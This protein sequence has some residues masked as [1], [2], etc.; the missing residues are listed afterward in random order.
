MRLETRITRWI[1][2]AGG[3]LSVAGLATFAQA[4]PVISN[5]LANRIT[6]TDAWINWSTD[7][8]ADEQVKYGPALPYSNS[9]SLPPYPAAA[10]RTHLVHLTAL[11]PNTL[12]HYLVT[13]ADGTGS[14]SSTDAT[15]TT[16]PL[17]GTGHV[18][19][20]LLKDDNS[21]GVPNAGE[22]YFSDPAVSPCSSAAFPQLGLTISFTSVS[23][24]GLATSIASCDSNGIPIYSVDLP[25]GVYTAL[26]S[27]PLFQ[28]WT[29]T[30]AD[31]V[32]ITVTDGGSQVINF[33]LHEP[34]VD[35]TSPV[36]SGVFATPVYVSSASI[37]WTT[38][39]EADGEVD[40][41]TTTSY[42]SVALQPLLA[43]GRRI[44][45]T[46][47]TPNTLYHFQVKS[48]D[49]SGNQ[50][51]AGDFTFTTL[52][53]VVPPPSPCDVNGDGNLTVVDVQLDVNAALGV[54]SCTSTYDINKDGQCTVVDVQRVVNAVLGGQCVTQ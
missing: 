39:E 46:G 35:V 22:Q 7:V 36:I 38:D 12:Y 44:D 50:S 26:V 25:P 14:S 32:P 37:Q 40:Y 23:N 16:F 41:G 49:A 19:G 43:V 15:F 21:N 3:L 9:T 13:S 51:T 4:T 6:A 33:A 28:G 54:I 45:L 8:N 53:P 1:I 20:Y 10:F 42:G 2:L 52:P 24:S 47:L 31:N 48:R 17:P 18:Q 29:V 27:K 34:A 5:V 30:S 11:T